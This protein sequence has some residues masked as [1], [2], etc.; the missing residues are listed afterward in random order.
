MSQSGF[1]AITYN[2]KRGEK[3]HAQ[4]VIGFGFASHRLKNGCEIFTQIS[5]GS[6][7]NGVITFDSHLKTAL[8]SKL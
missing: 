7:R 6:N 5:K 2:S 8:S 3:S 1:L 4:G